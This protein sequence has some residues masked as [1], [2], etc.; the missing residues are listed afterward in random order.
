MS[1]ERKYNNPLDEDGFEII[2][3]IVQECAMWLVGGKVISPIKEDKI[4]RTEYT[5]FCRLH[6]FG[7][8]KPT[9]I[10]Y[11]IPDEEV[12]DVETCLKWG[13]KKIKQNFMGPI[14]EE[15]NKLIREDGKSNTIERL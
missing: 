2:P 13:V 7:N 6:L 12:G 14:K 11:D 15:F 10:S 1:E 3:G 4:E 5:F 9:V 8:D